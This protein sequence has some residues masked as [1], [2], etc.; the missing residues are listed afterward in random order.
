MEISRWILGGPKSWLLPSKIKDLKET[1]EGR[2]GSGAAA[3]RPSLSGLTGPRGRGPGSPP[4]SP[5]ACRPGLAPVNRLKPRLV[6][7]MYQS[8]MSCAQSG[9]LLCVG[10]PAVWCGEAWVTLIAGALRQLTLR[11]HENVMIFSLDT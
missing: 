7:T 4:R 8:Q 1:W 10:I 6:E 9:K 2:E 3:R 5:A 11:R